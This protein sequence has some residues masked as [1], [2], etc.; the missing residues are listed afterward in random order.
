MR[1]SCSR[2]T[3]TLT[4]SAALCML[5]G[6]AAAGGAFYIKGGVMRLQDNGQVID[7][8]QR[9]LDETSN[10]TLGI[11]WEARK[12]NGL[13]FSIE[14]LNY[15]NEFT[16]PTSPSDG[17]ARTDVLQFSG[18]KYFIDGGIFHPYM[19]AGIGPGLTHIS[20]TS[21]GI[22]FTEDDFALVLHAVLGMELRFD[23]L[24]FMLEARHIYFNVDSNQ[25]DPTATGVLA[26]M[27][28][29]W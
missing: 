9:N 16:P 29:N 3:A 2:T 11:G 24:S 15:R 8:L 21:G 18:K 13:A 7:A 28:F 1:M 17:E 22:S 25:Y 23:N 26:G 19:G 14:Y 5:P 4:F 6:A 10:K 20:Y 12:K 27:G